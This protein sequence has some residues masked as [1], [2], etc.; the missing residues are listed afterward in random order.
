MPKMKFTDYMKSSNVNGIWSFLV[1]FIQS[2]EFK[3]VLLAVVGV[4]IYNPEWIV[5]LKTWLIGLLK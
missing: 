3:W 4:L 5:A 1:W 2:H